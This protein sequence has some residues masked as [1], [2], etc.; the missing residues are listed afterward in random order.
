MNNS[1]IFSDYKFEFNGTQEINNE[2]TAQSSLFSGIKDF[3]FSK[4]FDGI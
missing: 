4:E 3:L 1:L 2:P